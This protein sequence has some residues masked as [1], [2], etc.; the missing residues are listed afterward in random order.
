MA[1]RLTG[2]PTVTSVELACRLRI[3]CGMTVTVPT[4]LAVDEAVV[5]VAV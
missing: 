3:G 2:V 4:A 5:Q 1:E